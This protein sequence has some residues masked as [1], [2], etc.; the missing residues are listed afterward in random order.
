MTAAEAV[1][2]VFGVGVTICA[3]TGMADSGAGFWDLVAGGQE[4]G[5]RPRAL[6]DTAIGPVWEANHV[7][8]VFCIVTCWTAFG[9]AIGPAFASIM[10]TPYI[11]LTLA[12]LGI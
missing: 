9:P 8:L 1:A 5:R 12:V 4:R 10:S 11:P 6:L 3:W 7:W 2:A